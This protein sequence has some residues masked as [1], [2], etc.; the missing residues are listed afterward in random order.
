MIRSPA[1]HHRLLSTLRSSQL[2]NS[3]NAPADFDISSAVV[4]SNFVSPEEGKSILEDVQKRMQR[5]RYEKGHW[6]AVISDYKEIEL[7]NE[8]ELQE[9]SRNTLEKTRHLLLENHLDR[10]ATWLPCHAIDLKR[11]GE[12]KA[13]VDSVR[14]SGGMVAGISFLSSSI[15]RLRPGSEVGRNPEDGFVDL[16]LPPLSLYV[17]TGVS[18]YEYAHELLPSGSV[19]ESVDGTTVEVERQNRISIIFRD[20][21]YQ[22]G[23]T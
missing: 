7:I 20:A 2:V 4:Y 3:R 16:L 1:C 13:H 8:H 19:F 14:F 21:K 17:L 15:M 9:M 5:R 23:C 10:N 18:R 6:D 22:D 11:D 12:L